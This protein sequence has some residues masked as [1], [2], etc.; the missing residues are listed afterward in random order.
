MLQIIFKKKSENEIQE[1]IYSGSALSTRLP[2][3]PVNSNPNRT[4]RP[5]RRHPSN[6]AQCAPGCRGGESGRGMMEE[7]GGRGQGRWALRGCAHTCTHPS[8]LITPSRLTTHTHMHT[9][10]HHCSPPPLILAHTPVAGPACSPAKWGWS[11]WR[12][13]GPRRSR[14]TRPLEEEG[15]VRKWRWVSVSK[16]RCV[17]VS[18]RKGCAE[19]SS[20]VCAYVYFSPGLSGTGR[21]T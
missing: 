21:M 12:R 10:P 6:E 19:V 2:V 3:G 4:Q 7:D 18:K 20:S 5:T 11:P 15:G 16:G 9:H 8:P 13:S 1:I 17:S 14:Q